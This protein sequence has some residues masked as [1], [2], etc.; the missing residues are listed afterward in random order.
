MNSVKLQ[1]TLLLSSKT[2]EMSSYQLKRNS[3]HHS[4]TITSVEVVLKRMI[5]SSETLQDFKMHPLHP[6]SIV[7]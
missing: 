1:S 6:F 4:L 3:K 2:T 7:W 5:L